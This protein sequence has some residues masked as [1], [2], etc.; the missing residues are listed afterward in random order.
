MTTELIKRIRQYFPDL[1]INQMEV[2]SDGLMNDVLV[3]N[4]ERVF[5][6]ARDEE[7]IRESLA[8]EVKVL[9]LAKEYV[10][11]PVPVFDVQEADCVSYRLLPG[12][13]PG[14]TPVAHRSRSS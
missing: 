6:F 11:I 14:C 13:G 1:A 7:W 5:R 10:R 4:Q 3:V 12:Q 2:N 8:R 9:E